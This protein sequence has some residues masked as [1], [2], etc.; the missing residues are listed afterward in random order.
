MRKVWIVL[1]AGLSVGAVALAVSMYC[2]SRHDA[3][4]MA[5]KE[6]RYLEAR[7]QFQPLARMGLADAQYWMGQ[8][9]AFGWG[10]KQYEREANYWF[11]RAAKWQT[12]GTAPEAAAQF[13]VGEAYEQGIGVEKNPMEADRWYRMAAAGGLT[14]R[15]TP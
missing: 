11:R 2:S 6:G 7:R 10:V 4:V 8:I 5:L 9:Y 13:F 15:P 3:A 1:A 14:R 12:T